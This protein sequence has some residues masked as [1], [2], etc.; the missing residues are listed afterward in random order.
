ME[1]SE[2]TI[3]IRLGAFSATQAFVKHR[4]QVKQPGKVINISSVREELP[5]PHF[6]SNCASKGAVKMTGTTIVVDDGLTWN[7]SEQQELSRVWIQ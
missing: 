4:M 1:N 5:F 6:I 7:Y 2:F 3:L